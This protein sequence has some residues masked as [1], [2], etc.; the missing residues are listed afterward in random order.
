[1]LPVATGST[2]DV[3]QSV[4]DD[5]D[6]PTSVDDRLKGRGRVWR[7]HLDHR[8]KNGLRAPTSSFAEV[9]VVVEPGLSQARTPPARQ[10]R[11]HA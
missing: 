2:A 6:W 9:R 1:M 10:V 11:A 8:S 5:R 7:C 3:E 4:S